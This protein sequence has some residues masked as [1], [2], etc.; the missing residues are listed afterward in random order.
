MQAPIWHKLL[1]LAALVQASQSWH[2]GWTP[3]RSPELLFGAWMP[4]W[5]IPFLAQVGLGW[6]PWFTGW[7]LQWWQW[8]WQQWQ[9]QRLWQGVPG[10]KWC[11]ALF[12]LPD[13]S[14][15]IPSLQAAFRCMATVPCSN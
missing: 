9:Q 11:L 15:H 14:H 13:T 4:L 6:F 5:F 2:M 12:L 10:W 3:D 7:Q 8:Q 1:G